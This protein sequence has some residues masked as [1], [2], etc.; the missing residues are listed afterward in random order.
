MKQKPLLLL[1]LLLLLTAC[2]PAQNQTL[3][4]TRSTESFVEV[5]ITL[6]RAAEG[7]A[8]LSATF[9]PTESKLH[10]YSKDIPLGGVDGLGRPALLELPKDSLI[11]INGELTESVPSQSLLADEPDLL[12]YP[13]GSITLT[14]PVTLPPGKDWFDDRVIVTY[15]ACSGYNCRPPVE[16]KVIPIH[17]PQ[18][19]AN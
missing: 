10:L 6:T 9:T 12:M 19:D 15:M 11:Q 7:Q 5:V 3:E 18:R 16:G 2:Q 14:L 4:L 13:E 8:Y 1:F 17:I